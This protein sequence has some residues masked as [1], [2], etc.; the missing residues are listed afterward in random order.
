MTEQFR[1]VVA[2]TETSKSYAYVQI[3]TFCREVFVTKCFLQFGV[4]DSFHNDSF[5]PVTKFPICTTFYRY[6][7]LTTLQAENELRWYRG[8]KLHNDTRDPVSG[9]YVPAEICESLNLPLAN[10]RNF[11]LRWFLHGILKAQA[12]STS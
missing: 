12:R 7:S 5:D 9:K 11:S 6:R 4:D 8:G 10:N 1:I 3:V 2:A